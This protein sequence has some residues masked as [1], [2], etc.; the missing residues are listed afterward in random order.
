LAAGGFP[1]DPKRFEGGHFSAAPKTNTGEGLTL[2][3][4]AGGIFSQ[5][6]AANAAY[7]PVSLVPSKDGFIHFPHLIERAKPGLM[8]V[9][10]NGKRFT[11]EANSYYDVVKDLLPHGDKCY[12]ICDKNFIDKYGLGRVRPRPFPKGFWVAN[13]YLKTGKTLQELA[14]VC[15]IESLEKT[16]ADYNAFALTGVDE[17][18]NRGSTA[19]NKIQG[20]FENAPNPCLKPLEKAPFY[21]VEI[22][23]GSLGTFQGLETTADGQVLNTHKTPI[24]GL[25]VAGNDRASMMG[26]HYPSGGIT[27]GPALV[28]GYLTALKIKGLR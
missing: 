15:G 28:F 4:Q 5:E 12:A 20:D 10:P 25:Y 16:V 21:A 2:G 19:Y 24:E 22:R 8:M 11:N 13:G 23:I 1:H 14:K 17:E 3:E 18:F 9:F 26:G 7:A 6:M 27:L